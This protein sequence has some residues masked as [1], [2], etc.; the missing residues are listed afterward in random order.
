MHTHTHIHTQSLFLFFFIRHFLYLHFKSIPKVPY[1]PCSSPAPQPTHS[2][3]LAPAFPCTGAYDLHKTKG[4]SSH[5]LGHLTEGF[6]K[7]EGGTRPS[8]RGLF[9]TI[10]ERRLLG[11]ARKQRG[12]VN[13]PRLHV[14]LRGVLE[15]FLVRSLSDLDIFMWTRC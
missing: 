10:R 5:W 2:Y 3:F 13:V 1:T 14:S 7:N 11:E 6:K 4:L 9:K 8:D 12:K 15:L